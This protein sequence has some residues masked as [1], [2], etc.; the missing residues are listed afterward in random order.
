MLLM[1]AHE[2]G[3]V[4]DEEQLLF[5]AGEQVTNFDDDVDDLALNVDHVFEADQCDAF[6]YDVNES[7]TTQSMFMANLT[8][9]EAGASYDSNIP[10]EVQDREY[11][12]DYE[13]KYHE[14]HEMQSVIQHYEPLAIPLD[15]I[16]IN[17]KLNFIEEPIEIMYREVRWLKQSRI[18]IMK[19]HW[20]SRR[21]SEFTWEREDQIKKN[22][23]HLFVNP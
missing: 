18:P 21:G 15:E 7:P 6:D 10:S 13:D 20:N 8:S 12:L 17:N 16:Q 9:E 11:D 22:Y 2:N 23:P 14:V 3:V 1:N 4:L 19:V 5:L